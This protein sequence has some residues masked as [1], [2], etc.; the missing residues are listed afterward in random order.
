MALVLL[1]TVTLSCVVQSWTLLSSR[2]SCRRHE[3]SSPL[4]MSIFSDV[5]DMLT[6]GK[7]VPQSSLPYGVPLCSSTSIASDTRILAVQERMLT[8]TG[9]DFDV[10]DA[11]TNER[12]AHV[13][14]GMLHLPGKDKM[15]VNV[16]GRRVAELDRKLVAMTPTYD[17][18]RQDG[19]KLGWIEKVAIAFTDTFNVY[20]EGQGGVGP[21]KTPA[22]RIEGDFLDRKFVH[23]EQQQ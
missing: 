3:S 9:E 17:I 19:T 20:I 23:E 7:L 14:G 1:L 11:E 8:F 13:S 2:L 10:Y 16:G 5:G 6:G 12:I 15:R 21:F 18:Y 4:Q 22:Y